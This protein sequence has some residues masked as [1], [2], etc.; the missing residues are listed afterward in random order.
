MWWL[1]MTFGRNG[2]DGSDPAGVF[3]LIFHLPGIVVADWL[4]LTRPADSVFVA[5]TGAVQF[6]L[7]FWIGLT[8]WRYKHGKCSA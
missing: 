8:I 6:F 2:A 5:S 3:G 1:I 4:H 7:A